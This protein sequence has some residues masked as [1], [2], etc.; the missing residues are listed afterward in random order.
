MTLSSHED[1]K[2]W[3][4][5]FEWVKREQGGKNPIR[6]MADGASD[7]T[8]AGREVRMASNVTRQGCPVGSETSLNIYFFF[9]LDRV[10]PLVAKPPSTY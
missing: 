2:A 1:H 5:T 8:K 10:A 6:R 7:I 3:G 4:S 9:K